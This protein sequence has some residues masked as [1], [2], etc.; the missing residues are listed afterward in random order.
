MRERV[1]GARELQDQCGF[2]NAHIPAS[3]VRKIC[4]LDEA[5]ERT[6]E[7]AV[8]RMVLSARAHPRPQSLRDK[9]QTPQ[10]DIHLA[11]LEGPHLRPVEAAFVCEN[12]LAPALLR[13][14]SRIRLPSRF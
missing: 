8:R 10:R 6:L 7:M 5:G 2:Y 1:C 13:R 14:S 11:P 4:A 12:V 9:Q 3:Q